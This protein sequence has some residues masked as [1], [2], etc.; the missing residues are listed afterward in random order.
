MDRVE[1]LDDYIRAKK[2]GAH[3]TAKE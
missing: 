1:N 3:E 2:L